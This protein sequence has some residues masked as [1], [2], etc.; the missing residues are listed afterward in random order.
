M[1]TYTLLTFK[2]NEYK[3][4]G[5]LFCILFPFKL[6][7]KLL[8]FKDKADCKIQTILKCCRLRPGSDAELQFMSRALFPIMPIPNYLDRLN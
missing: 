1:D 8:E 4:I 7:L 6:F 2:K 5:K 3:A